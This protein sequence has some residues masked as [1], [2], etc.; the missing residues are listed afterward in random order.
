[1][2]KNIKICNYALK[3]TCPYYY[4]LKKHMANLLANNI[5]STMLETWSIRELK[6]RQNRVIKSK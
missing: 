1:M 6:L 5:S 3:I 4:Y 2:R